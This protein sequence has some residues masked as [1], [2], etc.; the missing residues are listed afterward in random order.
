LAR[1]VSVGIIRAGCVKIGVVN[2][3]VSARAVS[4]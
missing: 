2:G 3:D 1:Y 4:V